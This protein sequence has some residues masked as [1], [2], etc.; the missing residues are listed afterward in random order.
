MRKGKASEKDQTY[1]WVER[2]R[3]SLVKE[4]SITMTGN[5]CGFPGQGVVTLV[6]HVETFEPVFRLLGVFKGSLLGN[7]AF[8]YCPLMVV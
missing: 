3:N 6:A 4:S 2:P 8:D 5:V 7:S 1:I